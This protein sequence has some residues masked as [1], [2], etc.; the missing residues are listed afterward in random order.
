MMSFERLLVFPSS[1]QESQAVARV[2]SWLGIEVVEAT[3]EQLTL[4]ER[5]R[6]V[7]FLPYV[8]DSSFDEAFLQLLMQQ[9]VGRVYTPHSGVWAC[10][11]S[12]LARADLPVTFLLTTALPH[13][14]SFRPYKEAYMV[15]DLR[16]D[17]AIDLFAVQPGVK[18]ASIRRIVSCVGT[19]AGT[20]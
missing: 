8:T 19:G 15:R 3:S 20:K 14:E 1:M 17:F 2:A 10:L 9:Q 12:L 5:E 11:D 6:G 18:S 4:E 16:S 13:V 7:L